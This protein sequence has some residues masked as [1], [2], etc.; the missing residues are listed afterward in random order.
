[1]NMCVV[2][3]HVRTV[4]IAGQSATD[5]S[6]LMQRPTLL[7]G[8][9][10][11]TDRWLGVLQ[12]EQLLVTS[13]TNEDD[14]VIALPL[15]FGQERTRSTEVGLHTLAALLAFLSSPSPPVI[16]WWPQAW[17]SIQPFMKTKVRFD[18]QLFFSCRAKS[19]KEMSAHWCHSLVL[20]GIRTLKT[21]SR[22]MHSPFWRLL[23]QMSPENQFGWT[24]AMKA[25]LLIWAPHLA[26]EQK[27]KSG[28]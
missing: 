13:F 28:F 5:F 25:S 6:V 26:S 7:C 11:S 12:C 15:S 18:L 4:C 1:M 9:E 19:W 20:L 24:V 17:C 23:W 3:V 21:G 10:S 14:V 8:F 2:H 16:V 27:A 22:G